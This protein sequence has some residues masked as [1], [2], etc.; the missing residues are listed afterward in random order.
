MKGTPKRLL[1]MMLAVG[2]LATTL[3]LSGCTKSDTDAK[4]SGATSSGEAE[5]LKIISTTFPGYDFAKQICGESAD[6]SI[7]VPLGMN[8]HSY[9]PSPQDIIAIQNCDLFIYVGN[10][11]ESWVK[12]ILDT[13]D[14]PV[15]TFVL[16]DQVSLLPIEPEDHDHEEEFHEEDHSFDEHVWTSPKNAVQLTQTLAIELGKLNLAKR[17]TYLVNA[18]DYSEKIMTLHQEFTDFFATVENKTMVIGDQFAMRYFAEEYD[19]DVHAAFPG[20]STDSEI[21]PGVLKE[22]I[23][24]V[25]KE[26]LSTVFYMQFSS[27]KIAES[28]AEPTNAKVLSLHDTHNISKEE[29]ESGATYVSLMEQNLTVFEEA[30]G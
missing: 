23:D 29:Q 3:L 14:Q 1:A 10:E 21:S 12:K 22:L 28:I 2:I 24:V 19:L 5:P 18:A 13:M 27:P 9:E 17:E 8:T 26:N 25:T 4:E 15:P 11:S 7:L 6:V 20:C 16:T 30:M